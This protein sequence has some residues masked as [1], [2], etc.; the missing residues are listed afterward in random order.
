GDQITVQNLA[1][2]KVDVERNLLLIKGNVPG[3]RKALIKVKSAV[4]AK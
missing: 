4:K 1:I 3:A 2:V